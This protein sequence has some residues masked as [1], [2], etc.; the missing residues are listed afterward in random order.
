M[1]VLC[2]LQSSCIRLPQAIR[3]ICV[4]MRIQ[5]KMVHFCVHFHFIEI[6][7]L[8]LLF[9][10]FDIS[11]VDFTRNVL[12]VN[13]AVNKKQTVSTMKYGT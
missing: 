1:L 12:A 5:N 8:E 3:T 6:V 2:I 9:Q 4:H 7:K 13:N 10:P 11:H